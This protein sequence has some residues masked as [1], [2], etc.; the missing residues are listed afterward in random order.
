MWQAYDQFNELSRAAFAASFRWNQITTRNAERFVKQQ[1]DYVDSAYQQIKALG[2]VR[3]P[4]RLMTAPLEMASEW[5]G[6]WM[7]HAR[8]SAE[9]M[10]EASQEMS[11]F[12]TDGWST[13]SGAATPKTGPRRAA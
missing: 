13:F 6:R 10:T 7:D 2:D 4:Q 9:I 1:L 3:D 11:G 5:S 12:L 8:K